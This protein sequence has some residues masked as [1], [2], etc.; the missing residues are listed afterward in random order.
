MQRKYEK[1]KRRKREKKAARHYR[2]NNR[3]RGMRQDYRPRQTS[4]DESMSDS[5]YSSSTSYYSSTDPSSSSSDSSSEDD[6]KTL[7]RAKK[8]EKE[9]AALVAKWRAE[10]RA[11]IEQE[12][13]EEEERRWCNH[14]FR[15][16]KNL[17]R[18][19]SDSAYKVLST[20]ETYICNL[21]LT[22]N[23]VA[24]ALVTMGCVWFKFMEENVNVCLPAHFRSPECTFPEF[25]GCFEC[26]IHHPVYRFV[27]MFHYCCS[28]I[29]GCLALTFLAKVALAWRVVIDELNSPTTSSPAGLICMTMVTVFAGRGIL[30]QALTC[31]AALFHFVLV[32]L[33]RLESAWGYG[34]PLESGP[35]R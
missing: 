9:Y 8:L 26:D 35:L 19:Y 12:R 29:A 14:F 33:G 30:G 32:G 34:T 23:A 21:P 5:S 4:E 6:I 2:K 11:D 24:L 13:R 22:I 15:Y 20:T 17:I 3:D 16:I 1:K 31:V 10:A 28:T 18:G 7:K 27:V 25:P